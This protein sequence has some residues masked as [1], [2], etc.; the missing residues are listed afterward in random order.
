MKPIDILEEG[1]G[2]TGKMNTDIEIQGITGFTLKE[3]NEL[4]EYQ[5]KLGFD[6]VY[7]GGWFAGR[8]CSLE[9]LKE[10]VFPKNLGKVA[11]WSGYVNGLKHC[12]DHGGKFPFV[13]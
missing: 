5:E 4:D 11:F 6:K 9:D 8:T 1:L 3:I 7:S 12:I 10:N 13:L 2:L